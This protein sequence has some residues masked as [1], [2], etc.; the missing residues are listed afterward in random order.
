MTRTDDMARTDTEIERV[1]SRWP[2]VTVEP[3]RFGGWEFRVAGHE[4]G[5][6][7]G[8]RQA[9]LPFPVRLRQELVAAGR[10]AP[11]H[12]LPQTGW[13]T[14]YIRSPADAPRVID[15]FKLNYDRITTPRSAAAGTRAADAHSTLTPHS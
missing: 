13:V 8:A 6:M 3:H 5:H 14:Y 10:A 15:L 2:G 4:I 1:V 9:D 7:H 12:L 11:H